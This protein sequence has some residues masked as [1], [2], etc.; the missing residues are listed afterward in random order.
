MTGGSYT[1]IRNA[2]SQ[3]RSCK[4]PRR[5]EPVSQPLPTDAAQANV[6]SIGSLYDESIQLESENNLRGN[7]KSSPEPEEFECSSDSSEDWQDPTPSQEH[8]PGG[9]SQKPTFEGAYGPYFPT[10]TAAAFAIFLSV[11][12]MS[13]SNF[14]TLIQILKHPEFSVGDLPSS[15][16]ACKQFLY[17]LPT[18]PI[19][20]RKL[21]IDKEHSYIT[22]AISSSAYHHSIGDIIHRIL[23]SPLRNDLYFGPG[24]KVDKPS[25]LWHG[26]LWRESPL[27]GAD[28]VRCSKGKP[29]ITKQCSD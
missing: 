26:T 16:N 15:F 3:Q 7:N 25:E 24:L 2:G 29:F 20:V 9:S 13:R 4:R 18:L 27:F 28:F 14:N 5:L 17:G 8:I 6:P 21:H 23:S 11:S 12:H 10:Y 22:K 1:R 19:H